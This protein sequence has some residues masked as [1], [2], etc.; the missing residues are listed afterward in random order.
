[1]R[2]AAGMYTLDTWYAH[3]KIRQI[4]DWIRTE[5][6]EERLGKKEAK[7]AAQD[8]AKARTRDSTRAFAKRTAEIDGELRIVRDPPL[9][10]PIEDLV[11]PGTTREQIERS[12]QKLMQA[13]RRTL[14][15]EHHPFEE[16][17]Y[18]HMARKVVGVGSV[19]TRGW[20]LLWW[21]VT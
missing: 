9:I 21:A 16:F 10:M 4:L 11:L 19:G 14:A 17:R 3:M 2:L 8:V 12:M 7:E 5:V 20:I 18:V 13:Y 1:M 6:K 15:H